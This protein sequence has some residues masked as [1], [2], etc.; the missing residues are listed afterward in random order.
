[1][2]KLICHLFKTVQ[3]LFLT[4]YSVF[5]ITNA[6][7]NIQMESGNTSTDCIIVNQL[8]TT[9]ICFNLSVCFLMNNK[10]NTYFIIV[11]WNG[12]IHSFFIGTHFIRTSNTEARQNV[13]GSAEKRRVL[14]GNTGRLNRI[15]YPVNSVSSGPKYRGSLLKIWIPLKWISC[16]QVIFMLF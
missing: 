10:I 16:L 8:V 2:L 3:Q 7:F 9:Y 15:L 11:T 4:I 13:T 1:M 5:L 6:N 14:S 12:K